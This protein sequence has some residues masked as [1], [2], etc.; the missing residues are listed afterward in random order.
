MTQSA[1]R[2][3]IFSFSVGNELSVRERSERW[4]TLFTGDMGD[5]F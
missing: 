5:T 2:N 1:I 4:V 3:I